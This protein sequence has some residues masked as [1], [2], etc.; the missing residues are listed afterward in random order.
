MAFSTTPLVGGRASK[1]K[2]LQLEFSLL[3]RHNPVPISSSDYLDEDKYKR[4]NPIIG[5]KHWFR[6]V[7]YDEQV[8]IQCRK[9]VHQMSMI[10]S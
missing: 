1:R 4:K 6:L 8:E 2:Y 5:M 3:E 9:I 7:N 10:I